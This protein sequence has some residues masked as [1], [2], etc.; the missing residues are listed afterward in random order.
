MKK[1]L[2]AA[3]LASAAVAASAP[4]I[5]Q[6]KQT[7][8]QILFYTSDWK[9]ERFPDGRPKVADDLLKRAVDCT[10]ED[11]WGYLRQRGYRNQYE[12]GWMMLHDDRPFAGRAL[13]VQYMPE[14]P[15]M[16]AAITA[17]GKKEGR[18]SG[19]NSWP[20]AELQEGDVYIADGYGKSVEGTLIGS[21][22]GNGIYGKSHNGFVFDAAIRDQEENRNIAGFNGFY[23]SVDPSAIKDMDMT[24]INVPIRI[25]RA[26]VLPGDVVLAKRDG[27]LIIPAAL[28]EGAISSAEFTKL[29]DDYNFELN[30]ANRNG[31]SVEG[32]WDE[33][34][35]A[36]F[37]KWIGEHPEKVKM[38]KAEYEEQYKAFHDRMTRER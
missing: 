37:R 4:A 9:G 22:L 36:G 19:H 17:E 30:L 15:D 35:F 20:I 26:T 18:V 34:K 12:G 5:A 8:E 29:T 23:R 10:I 7:R 38:S 25:G 27:V 1:I 31:G 32:G 24:G 6:V 21:N 3:L 14:R 16:N 33:N 2:L 13:T 28:A 11:I